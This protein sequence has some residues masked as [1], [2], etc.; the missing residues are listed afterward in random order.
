MFRVSHV[1]NELDGTIV[2]NDES[3]DRSLKITPTN[4]RREYEF[5]THEKIS[6]DEFSNNMGYLGYKPIRSHGIRYYYGF[7]RK[8]ENSE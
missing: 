6:K 4:L 1:P 3:I 2:L 7:K 8:E 5:D